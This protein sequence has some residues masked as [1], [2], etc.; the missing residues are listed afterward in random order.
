[1]DSLHDHCEVRDEVFDPSRR[2]TVLDL[3]D[4]IEDRINARRFFKTNYV[5]S[6]MNT[7]LRE[8]F[9]RFSRQSQQGTFLLNQAMGGGKTHNM[10]A[11]GLLAKHPEFRDEVLEGYHDP[12]LG[13]VR[14]AAFTGRE[15]DAPL[16]I[17]GSIAEQIGKKQQFSDYYQPLSPPGQT[18]WVNLLKGE[19]LLILLDELPPYLNQARAKEIGNA[20]LATVTTTALANLLVAVGRPELENVCVVISDLTATYGEGS[21]QINEALHDLKNEANRGALELEPVQQ[22]TNE[23]YHILRKQIFESLPPEEEIQ[24]VSRAYAQ[25]VK[26]A[27]QMDVTDASPE[28]YARRIQEAYPFH[29][30]IRDLYARFREN[31]GFQQTRDL[32]RLMRTVVARM[33][34]SERAK[35]RALVHP[36]D[37]DLNH[38]DTLTQV[39]RIN[40]KL[41][42]AISHD[43]A[44]DGNAVAETID[45]NRE[46]Q[47]AQDAATLLL[48]AS[49]ANVPDAIRGLTRAEVVSLLCTPDRDVSRIEQEVLKPFYTSAWYLHTD[50]DGRLLFKDVQNINA[51]LKTTSESYGRK[52]RLVELRD[53]LAGLFEPSIEDVYQRVQALPAVDEITVTSDKVTLV[54]AEPSSGSGLG[55]DLQAFYDD[56]EYKNRVLFLTGQRSTLQHLLEKSARLKAI[57]HILEEMKAEKVSENDPQYTSAQEIRDEVKL[58]LL[59]AAR[60]TF[61]TLLFPHFNGLRSADFVMQFTDNSY[62][63]E[64]Q[65]RSTLEEK[66][67]FTADI[68][69]DSFRKKCQERLF[70]QKQML[71]S[72]VKNRAAV[73]PEWPWHRPDALRRLKERMLHED[74]WQQEGNYVD[75]GPF[76]SP[77]THVRV[78]EIHRDHDSGEVTLRLTPVHGDT[79]YYEVGAEATKASEEV[80]DPQAFTTEA[81][82]VSFLCVDSEGEHDTGEPVEWTNEVTI[83]HKVYPDAEGKKKVELK[84]VP[85]VPIRYTT[86]GSNPRQAGGLYDGP[87]EA[88]EETQVVQAVAE[89]DGVVSEPETIRLDWTDDGS[90]GIQDDQP[91]VWQRSHQLGTTKEAYDFLNRMQKWDATAKGP[92]VTVDSD[93]WVELAFDQDMEVDGETLEE[94]TE[95]VRGLIDDGEVS[96]DVDAL[97]FERGQQLRDWAE[98][99]KTELNPDE[100][101]Q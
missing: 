92:R 82:K 59:S 98:D 29:F 13:R 97:H 56:L 54:L 70:T 34:D 21:Q 51:R 71:W 49:L 91:A 75:K 83:K 27:K 3:T 32:I 9:D 8:A 22:N 31:P 18:A 94:A 42:N 5:T 72:E 89:G 50:T 24:D 20:D 60:E 67:K 84:A 7:L 40:P 88:T 69:G 6:G 10:I 80:T 57:R 48:M 44:S 81:L 76:P 33:Y 63:G 85:E 62:N 12:N 47:D 43:I 87:I 14:V 11:L 23:I 41:E 93:D 65:V 64:E 79:I 16:G 19:P 46:G 26:D 74:Q 45:E 35:E 96:L 61:T 36:Y 4:L 30:S 99:A 37:I 90:P 66:G 95:Y 52:S 77:E 55:E 17:W 1:M 86:D 15:S 78:R 2:D 101:Q 39:T 100:V 73:Y 58:Q 25:S 68:E 38:K 53:F 28:E